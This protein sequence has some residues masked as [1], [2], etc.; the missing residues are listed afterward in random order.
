MF[1]DGDWLSPDEYDEKLLKREGL[2]K[3]EGGGW[4][5]KENIEKGRMGF[6]R[7]NEEWLKADEFVAQWMKMSG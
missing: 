6:I 2:A 7:V 4:E 3:L 1:S 5:R